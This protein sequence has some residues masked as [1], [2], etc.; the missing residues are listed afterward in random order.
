M[1]VSDE[2]RRASDTY[3]LHRIA[4]SD[5]AVGK[6]FAVAIADGRSDNVLYDS[7]RDAVIHQRHN[8]KFYGFIQIGPW[9]FTPK[10]ADAFLTLCRR[11]YDAGLRLTDPDHAKGGRE[12]IRRVSRAD[13]MRQIRALF[14]GDAPP[15]NI[16]HNPR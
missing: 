3:S 7:K 9:Q 5:G 11:M 8:E 14:K 4:N 15:T 10:D 1:K 2:A 12:M 16:I 6:W 13:Q